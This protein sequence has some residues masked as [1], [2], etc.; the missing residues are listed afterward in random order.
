MV[1]TIDGYRVE[2]GA[3]GDLQFAVGEANIGCHDGFSGVIKT[4]CRSILES[5]V[6]GLGDVSV[7]KLETFDIFDDVVIEE[8]VALGPL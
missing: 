8:Y 6:N 7:D 1:G 3:V 5:V 4:A 2:R